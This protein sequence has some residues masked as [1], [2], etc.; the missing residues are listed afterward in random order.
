MLLWDRVRVRIP[1]LW[2]GGRMIVRDVA[3]QSGF[4]NKV[5]VV[6]AFAAWVEWVDSK[7]CVWDCDHVIFVYR[8]VVVTQGRDVGE[9]ARCS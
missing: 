3:S 9:A 5:D 2:L 1:D 4:S 7:R 8:A 6:V